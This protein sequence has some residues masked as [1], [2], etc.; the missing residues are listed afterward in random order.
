M[1]PGPKFLD[2]IF[3]SPSPLPTLKIFPE[4]VRERRKRAVG[5][6]TRSVRFEAWLCLYGPRQV[7][8]MHLFS[9]L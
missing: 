5:L 2:P 9:L 4:V 3:G 8:S 7:N 6:G 1:A